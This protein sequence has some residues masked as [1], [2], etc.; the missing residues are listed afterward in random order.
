M[1]RII[2][3]PLAAC[4]SLFLLPHL[5]LA[6]PPTTPA[7]SQK[8]STFTLRD[9][10]VD[11]AVPDS[12]AFSALGLTPEQVSRPTTPRQLASSFLNGIDRNGNLQT[13][14]AI[15]T[16][17]YMLLAGSRITLSD[18]QTGPFLT[19]FLARWQVSFASAKGSGD[20]DKSAKLALGMRFTVFDQGDPRMDNVLVGCLAREAGN[21][22]KGSPPIP[23]FA[24]A[25]EQA[26]MLQQREEQ[27]RIAVKPCREAAAK[28][29]WNR[30][31]WIAGIAPTWTSADG[32][33]AEIDYSGTA[34]WTS[35]GYG[36]ERVPVL[37]DHAMIAFYLK[38]RTREIVPDVFTD[39]AFVTQ[40]SVTTGFRF[41]AGS[42]TSQVNLELLWLDNDRPDGREDR[43]WNLGIGFEQRLVDNTW[44][45]LSFGRQ[46]ARDASGQLFVVGAFNWG[47][48]ARQ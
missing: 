34:V 24:S 14:I 13:G 25:E 6:Q 19:R 17:P 36:F 47:L 1:S 12:P 28:R 38:G 11:L 27:V 44:L 43:Y 32:S 39:G 41:L 31:A 26:T 15:D 9:G 48:G 5:A 30:T 7:S 22:L 21:V 37:Q 42:P 16:A 29:R 4:L 23:P 10:T 18:Y 3:N 33:T 46:L 45:N 40:D 2:P 35:V 8:P 20:E